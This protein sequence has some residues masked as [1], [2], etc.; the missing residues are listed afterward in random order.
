MN[1]LRLMSTSM[2]IFT[3]SIP[4]SAMNAMGKA[5]STII[6]KTALAAA[7]TMK[8]STMVLTS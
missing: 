3:R 7:I 6:M 8:S 1:I 4:T 5:M 2:S